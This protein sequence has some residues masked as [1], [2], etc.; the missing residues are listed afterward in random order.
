MLCINFQLFDV[1]SCILL[2]GPVTPENFNEYLTIT[3]SVFRAYRK[4]FNEICKENL[5][6]LQDTCYTCLTYFFK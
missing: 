1:T 5:E 6:F 2:H 3:V 4:I